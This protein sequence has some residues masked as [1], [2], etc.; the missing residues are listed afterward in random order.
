MTQ[1]EQRLIHW[2]RES[3]GLGEVE[4]EPASADASF[5]RYFRVRLDDG[6]TRIVMDA[7]LEQ[8]DCRPF[9]RIARLLR[10]AGVHVPAV[11]AMDLDAGFM[12]LEDLGRRAYLE[13]LADASADRLYGDAIAALL[14]MQTAVDPAQLPPYDRELLLREMHLFD[15]WLLRRHLDIAPGAQIEDLLLTVYGALADNALSQPRVCV[16]R[17][18]HSRNLMMVDGDNPGVIDFQDAVAGPVTY[19]LVSLLRDCYLRWQPARVDGWVAGYWRQARDAG[20]LP[21]VELPTFVT[22]FD[23]MGVQRHLKAAGIFARLWHRDGKPGYLDDIPRTLG[24]I[25]EIG[26]RRAEVAELARFIDRRV[27]PRL[28]AN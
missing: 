25:V 1:R 21:G 4:L 28:A 7:P 6:T 22:W 23:L 10:D 9:A 8:E 13:A 16:H 14:R 12:L 27:L 5:R 24:Y 3:C 19:D 11:F 15:G 26:E 18:Y 20:L 2:L 17:D